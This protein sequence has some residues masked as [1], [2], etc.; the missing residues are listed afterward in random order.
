MQQYSPS[1]GGETLRKMIKYLYMWYESVG[2][3]LMYVWKMSRHG[4]DSWPKLWKLGVCSDMGLGLSLCDVPL[5][6]FGSQRSEGVGLECW[7]KGVAQIMIK[8]VNNEEGTNSR[9]WG[10]EEFVP[11]R[12]EHVEHNEESIKFDRSQSKLIFE[13][14]YRRVNEGYL[15]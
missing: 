15:Y 9:R 8:I 11:N 1:H 13:L 10:R 3:D 7:S 5:L 14:K 12:Q 4:S 6:Q 2:K